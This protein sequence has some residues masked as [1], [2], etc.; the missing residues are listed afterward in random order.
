[1]L[2]SYIEIG[3]IFMCFRV[4][5][6]IT[7]LVMNKIHNNHGHIFLVKKIRATGVRK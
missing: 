2:V 1:V 6:M 5:H 3:D 7:I 4:A